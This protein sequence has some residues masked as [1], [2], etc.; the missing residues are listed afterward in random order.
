MRVTKGTKERSVLPG[1][2]RWVDDD[3]IE[4]RGPNIPVN[5]PV[6]RELNWFDGDGDVHYKRF[7][8]DGLSG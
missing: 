1:V 4:T 2:L 6:M 8:D 7:D 5:E 3:G